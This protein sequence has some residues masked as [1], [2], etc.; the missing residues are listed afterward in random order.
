MRRPAAP[1][2]PYRRAEH[3]LLE[4]TSAALDFARRMRDLLVAETRFD[5]LYG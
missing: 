4:A 2:N 1:D 3:E 5:Q